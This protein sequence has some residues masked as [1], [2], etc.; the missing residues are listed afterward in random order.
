MLCGLAACSG[1]RTADRPPS[2]AALQALEDVQTEYRA[3]H[4]GQVIRSVARSDELDTAPSTVKVPALK[5]LAFSY[6]VS[7][8][9]PLCEDA[10]RRILAID[11]DFEL[12]PAEIGHPVWGPAYQ[13]AKQ[14]A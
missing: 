2:A 7:G 8:Y 10:F 4:Y 1:L 13:R 14:A 12:K 3:G 9:I 5:L 11:P 6:C